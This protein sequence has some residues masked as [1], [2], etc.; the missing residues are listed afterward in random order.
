MIRRSDKKW[1]TGWGEVEDGLKVQ[2]LRMGGWG[3]EDDLKISPYLDMVG[4]G[5]RWFKDLT[6]S[7]EHG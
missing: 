1:R 3:L 2:I 5:G 7:G 6:M 4:R